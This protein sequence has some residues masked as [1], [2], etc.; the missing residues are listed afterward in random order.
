MMRVLLLIVVLA[1]SVSA[2]TIDSL[3]WMSGHWQ[4]QSNGIVAEEIWT[5]PAGAMLIGMHRDV[6][7]DR[8][9]FEFMRI[10]VTSDGIVYFAQPS[11]RAA[12][13]FRLVESVTNR[14]VFANPAHDFPQRITY[15]REGDQLCAKVEGPMNGKDANQQ[16]CWSKQ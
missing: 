4:S 16:W 9:S 10:N 15:W 14:A 13:Q 1:F 3:A 12:V 11:G 8:A 5:S 6:K 2:E 7:G